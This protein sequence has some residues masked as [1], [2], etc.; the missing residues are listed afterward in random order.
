MRSCHAENRTLLFVRRCPPLVILSMTS[1]RGG[2]GTREAVQTTLLMFQTN[3]KLFTTFNFVLPDR[4]I[5]V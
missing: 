3:L 5:W 2:G 1:G 4:K